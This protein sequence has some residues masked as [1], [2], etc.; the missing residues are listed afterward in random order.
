MDFNFYDIPIYYISFD[1]NISLEEDLKNASFTNVNMFNAVRGKELNADDLLKNNLITLRSY[2]DLRNGRKENFGI[3]SLGAIGC[4][5]SHYNLWKKCIEDNLDYMIILENDVLIEKDKLKQN[6]IEFIKNII[7]KEK[8]I[9]VSPLT[10]CNIQYKNGMHEF[11]GTHFY[12]VSKSACKEL[13]KYVFPIDVQVDFYIAS[14]KTLGYINLEG[15]TIFRQKIHFSSIQ[16]ICIICYFNNNLL[17]GILI[18]IAFLIYF[19]YQCKTKKI[20]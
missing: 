19:L 20:K 7:K 6:D 9:F 8:G 5:L 10:F 13:I 3:S 14:L 17:I 18:F 1:K 12:I 15:Y 2:N 11:N 4:T 16:D